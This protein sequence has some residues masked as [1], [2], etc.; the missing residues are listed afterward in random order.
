MCTYVRT[1]TRNLVKQCNLIKFV[2]RLGSTS[3][4]SRPQNGTHQLSV[5]VFADAAG[6]SPSGQLRFIAGLLIGSL[7]QGSLFLS[8]AWTSHFSKCPVNSI[9]CAAVL[10][11][12]AAIDEG[13]MVANA[14]RRL[15]QTTINLLVVV[16]SKDLFLVLS[17]SHKPEDNSV[18]ADIQLMRYNLEAH[19]LNTLIWI[20]GRLNPGDPLTKADSPLPK[21]FSSC[22]SMDQ[23]QLIYRWWRVANARPH[24]ASIVSNGGVMS[25]LRGDLQLHGYFSNAVFVVVCIF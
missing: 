12:C 14:Y 2:K 18:A 17:S 22:C 16:D 24:L 9:A 1:Y 13:K 4:L 15:L 19:R 7:T 21:P 25:K 11:S 3:S 23:F 20:P 5:L 8:N 10:A 6:P